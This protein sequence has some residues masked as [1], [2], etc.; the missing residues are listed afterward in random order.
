[1][2]LAHQSIV[3]MVSEVLLDVPLAAYTTGNVEW[4]DDSRSDVMLVPGAHRHYP[5][6]LIEV[7]QA[8]NEEFLDRVI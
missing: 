3:D 2:V 8:V 5:P 7:Q 1:Q 4:K 6:I